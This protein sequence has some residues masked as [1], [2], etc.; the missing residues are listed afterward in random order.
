MHTRAR[1]SVYGVYCVCMCR[2]GAGDSHLF[3]LQCL[4][5][6]QVTNEEVMQKSTLLKPSYCR[7]MCNLSRQVVDPV[8]SSKFKI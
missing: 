5:R 8:K 2:G 6:G 1:K 3:C 7:G 4:E